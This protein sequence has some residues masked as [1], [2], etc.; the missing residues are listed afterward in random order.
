MRIFVTGASGALGRSLLPLLVEQGHEVTA[1][2]RSGVSHGGGSHR[3]VVGDL[4][5]PTSYRDEIADV[6][7]VLHMAAVTHTNRAAEYYRVNRDGTDTLLKETKRAGIDRFVFVSTRAVGPAG[8]AYSD[9]KA[10]AEELVRGSGLQ[11][12]IL[13]PA[14]VYGLDQAEMI[15]RLIETVGSATFVVVPGDGSYELAPLHIDD[16]VLAMSRLI[17]KTPAVI[18]VFT[19]AGP[20]SLSFNEWIDRIAG[21]RGVRPLK[22]HVSLALLSIAA[23]AMGLIR[24]R[25]PPIVKDQVARLVLAKDADIAPARR[26]IDFSPRTLAEHLALRPGADS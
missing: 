14:E 20:E 3:S 5:R 15:G 16:L 22:I 13:R 19:L 2:V 23:S 11:W 6:D 9:S 1:L 24:I 25:R 26:A 8:G 18:G 17:S 12:L 10:Q 7:A 4:L 21:A